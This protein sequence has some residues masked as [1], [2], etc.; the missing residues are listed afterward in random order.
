MPRMEIDVSEETVD[1]ILDIWNIN[2]K[3]MSEE[4]LRQL[5][6]DDVAAFAGD[7]MCWGFE[8]AAE[9]PRKFIVQMRERKAPIFKDTDPQ[10]ESQRARAVD[11]VMKA[12]V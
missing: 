11:D 7:L 4:V 3:R 6:W 12:Y 8:V 2:R 10:E 5:G 9:D 1:M